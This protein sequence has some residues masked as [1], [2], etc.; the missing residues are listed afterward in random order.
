MKHKLFKKF[1]RGLAK[2]FVYVMY[3]MEYIG[4][5]NFPKTG[6]HIICPNH[7][8]AMD[9]PAVSSIGDGKRWTYFMAK[10]EFFNNWF[11]N[12]FFTRLSVYPVDREKADIVSFR[13][14]T[15]YLKDDQLVVVFPQGTRST[16]DEQLPAKKGPAMFAAITGA[17]IVPVFIE[18]K[19][20]FR[21]KVKV[22]VG[23]PFDLELKQKTKYTKQEYYD[24]SQEIMKVIYSLPEVY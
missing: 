13:K 17:K 15:R 16:G 5:K 8:H 2:V 21:S 10:K 24:K 22:Y 20:K 7:I 1:F 4:E 12:W 14:T 6:A 19:F 23:K 3:N 9:I 11:L 18:G